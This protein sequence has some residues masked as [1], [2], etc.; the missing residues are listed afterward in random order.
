MHLIFSKDG[1]DH[2]I[3]GR[4]DMLKA[5]GLEP[6]G[7]LVVMTDETGQLVGTGFGGEKLLK[8]I[9]VVESIRDG[10]LLKSMKENNEPLH[11]YRVKKSE[12]SFGPMLR[13]LEQLNRDIRDMRALRA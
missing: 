1:T 6:T 13:E 12:S 7:R 4:D 9:P 8:S 5:L 2:V 3:R 10:S 11:K